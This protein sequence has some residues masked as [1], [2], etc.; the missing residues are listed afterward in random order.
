MENKTKLISGADEKTPSK[1]EYFSWINNTNEGSTE[2]QTLINL[3]FFRYLNRTYGMTL[4]IYAWDAGNLD[5]SCG[6]YETVTSSKLQMQYPH[7]YASV[8]EAAKAMGTRMGVWGGADGYGNTEEEAQARRDLLVGLCRDYNWA[9][10]KFDTVCGELRPEKRAEFAKTMQACRS[11]S[12]DLILLNHRN[13]LGEVEKYA[14]TFLWEGL[15]TYTDVHG[16]NQ[17]TAPHNRAFM[18]FRGYPPEL[19]RLTEDHGVC[20]SSSVDFFEDELVYQAFNRSLI[21]AP[22][23]YGNPWFLRDDELP[24]L[25]RIFNL[26]RRYRDILVDGMIPQ[27]DFGENAAVRGDGKR[28]FLATGNASWREKVIRIPLNGEIGLQPCGRVCVTRRFPVEEFIGCFAYGERAEVSLPAFRAG[29]IE[30]CDAGQADKQLTG[31]T[32]TVLHENGGIPDRVNILSASGEISVYDPKTERTVQSG[33][34]VQP[35]DLRLRDPVKCGS[36]QPCEAPDDAESIYERACIDAD[37]DSLERRSLRRSGETAIPEVQAARDAFFAQDSY[38]LRGLD[39]DI[40]F[41]G[42]ENSIFDTKSRAYRAFEHGHRVG[43]G[44]LRVDFGE[45]TDADRIEIEFF[46]EEGKLPE[47]FF[48][49]TVKDCAE[50]SSDLKSWRRAPLAEVLSLGEKTQAYFALYVDRYSLAHGTRKKAVFRTEGAFRYLR[51]PE[52]IDRI[53]SIKLFSG[54]EERKPASPKLTN[55]FAPY[56]K[57]KCR[58]AAKGVFTLESLP[59]YPYLAVACEG[60]TG[61]ENAVCCAEIEGKRYGFPSRAPAYYA[62][63]YEFPVHPTDGYYTFFLPVKEEWRGK[64]IGITVLF[65]G[66]S[67]PVDVYLCDGNG[68]RV[69]TVAE[70]LFAE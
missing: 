18:F 6:T 9:L 60:K 22:E 29:L 49:Q 14:T 38:R 53:Y 8:A 51:I 12:P 45:R 30:I 67:V 19:K 25:A 2:A 58:S 42:D 27:G 41:D 21:L 5:G 17:V 3:A 11:Y 68:K 31:C 61:H 26:H 52:P 1:S 24:K 69:G 48:D 64:P 35:F 23:I 70:N 4:D 59:K 47:S 57:K 40:P 37:N 46:E 16:Y 44:C 66:E 13:D 50:I 28:R 55:L 65:A 56:A 10:F 33:V 34:A 36:L 32:Y 54:E 43:G 62:N 20:I 15:E 63:A 39:C 7:G